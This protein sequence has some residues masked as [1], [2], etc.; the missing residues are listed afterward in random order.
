M[1]SAELKPISTAEKHHPQHHD[2]QPRCCGLRPGRLTQTRAPTRESL[3]STPPPQLP[4]PTFSPEQSTLDSWVCRPSCWG[5][6]TSLSPGRAHPPLTE[7]Q[8]ATYT[9]T[10]STGNH[11][12]PPK[13]DP[14]PTYHLQM[15]LKSPSFSR[16]HPPKPCPFFLPL[17][18]LPITTVVA[19]TSPVS[20]GQG[21]P[22]RQKASLRALSLRF[23]ASSRTPPPLFRA[24]SF[25]MRR[26]SAASWPVHG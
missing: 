7:R 11:P 19:L 21:P 26:P 4:S 3:T 12:S 24:P 2:L 6:K 5:G 1:P 23:S 17:P 16:P 8:P 25:W 20:G 14:P 10:Y 22:S 15:D 13:K 9:P 18:R